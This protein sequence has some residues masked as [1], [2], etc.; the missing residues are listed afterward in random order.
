MDAQR[1]A[2]APLISIVV[3]PA[4]G[5]KGSTVVDDDELYVYVYKNHPRGSTVVEEA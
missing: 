5:W 2:V 4:R 3:G 1:L